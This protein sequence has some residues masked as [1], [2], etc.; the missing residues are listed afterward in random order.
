MAS[1]KLPSNAR[2]WGHELL[3]CLHDENEHGRKA[4]RLASMLG[5]FPQQEQRPEVV[6]MIADDYMSEI[7]DLPAYAVDRGVRMLLRDAKRRPS[8]KELREACDTAS[9]R[10]RDL[11]NLI[12]RIMMNCGS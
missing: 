10:Y 9:F 3:T 6:A 12:K 1:S 4:L 5:H 7:E 8:M 2:E 11:K